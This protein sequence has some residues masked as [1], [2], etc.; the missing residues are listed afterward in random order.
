MFFYRAWA[1]NEGRYP[2]SALSSPDFFTTQFAYHRW[3]YATL[4]ILTLVACLVL[5]IVFVASFVVNFSKQ[6]MMPH[7]LFLLLSIRDLLV[8]IILIPICIDWFIINVGYFEGDEIFCKF[9]GFLDFFLAAEYPILLIMLSI[10]LYTRKYPKLEEGNFGLP[11]DEFNPEPDM[12][13]SQY[14]PGYRV[15]SRAH[16]TTSSYRAQQYPNK[17]PSVI[18]SVNGGYNGGGRRAPSVVGSVNGYGGQQRAPSVVGSVNGYGGQQRAPSVVGSV[19]GGGGRGGRAPSVAG[20]DTGYRSGGNA[21]RPQRPVILNQ[22]FGTPGR[23]GSVT[24]SI[25]GRLAAGRR[26]QQLQQQHQTF[27]TRLVLD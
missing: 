21:F 27:L 25:E 4:L 20:S 13:P 8:A 16:S 5:N 22:Q 6:K 3:G 19:Q 18:G 1:G 24:G 12:H 2:Q 9:A 10:I 7:I 23:P 26:T 15:P 17:P 11:M 14:D